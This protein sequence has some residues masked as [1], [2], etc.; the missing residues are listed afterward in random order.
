MADTRPV[1]ILISALGGEGG[2]VMTDWI[3]AAARDQ[4]LICQATSVPGVAQRTGATTYYLEVF[5]E[6]LEPGK[7]VSPANIRYCFV[8]VSFPKAGPM[9]WNA[10][11][12]Q[13]TKSRQ[14]CHRNL[15]RW[16]NVRSVWE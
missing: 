3:I 13:H 12:L 10:N 14:V 6:K 4:N 16:D 15:L 1:T 2:G 7:P 8:D 11:S 9:G 5:R